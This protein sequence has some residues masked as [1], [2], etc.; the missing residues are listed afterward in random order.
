MFD[1]SLLH[2]FPYNTF[3]SPALSSSLSSTVRPLQLF[4]R[5]IIGSLWR[6]RNR[7]RSVPDSLREPDSHGFIPALRQKLMHDVRSRSLHGRR[8]SSSPQ[9]GERVLL[10]TLGAP[11][12][13]RVL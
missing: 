4:T 5:P 8:S 12:A 11:T 9:L 13:V 7:R 2:I 6:K 3:S 10:S 1:C